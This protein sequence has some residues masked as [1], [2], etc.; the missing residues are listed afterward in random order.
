ML[1]SI[2]NK[3]PWSLREKMRVYLNHSRDPEYLEWYYNHSNKLLK[4]KNIHKG[5]DCFILGNGPSLNKMDLS[6]LKNYHTFGLNKIY[7]MFDT[8]D[9]NLSYHVAVNPL[10]IEQGAKEF[11]KLSCPSFL[12]YHPSKKIIKNLDHIYYLATGGPYTFSE[13]I[14]QE[15]CEGYTVTYVALQI[16]YYMGFDNV[17]VI[18]VDHNFTC[19]GNPNDEQIMEGAD[20]NHFH[21]DYFSGKSWHLPDLEASELS[22]SL[23][24]FFYTRN[25]KNIYDATCEGRLNIFPKISY[26]QAL[27]SCKKK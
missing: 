1:Y 18:G 15:I 26:A 16:A 6:P 5:E 8:I 12:S 25:G 7:L 2:L 20:A 11:E 17:Y 22:Y 19:A 3:L 13:N 4:F 27:N 24:R 21:P 9:L 10:V 23:A 14:I